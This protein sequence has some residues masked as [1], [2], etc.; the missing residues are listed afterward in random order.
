MKNLF[1][2]I[3]LLIVINLLIILQVHLFNFE[4]SIISLVAALIYKEYKRI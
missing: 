1:K 2:N 3:L 4:G